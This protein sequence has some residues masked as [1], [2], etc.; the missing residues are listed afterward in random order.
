MDDHEKHISKADENSFDAAGR[1]GSDAWSRLKQAAVKNWDD[2]MLVGESLIEGRTWAMDKAGTNRPEG[3]GY[4]RAFGE[5]LIRYRLDD[6]DKG[7]RSRLFTVME[8]RIEIEGWRIT[9]TSTERM[10]INH[11]STV[12]RKWSAM[13]KVHSG[14]KKPRRESSDKAKLAEKDRAIEHLKEQLASAERRDGSLCDFKHDTAGDIATTLVKSV[15]PSKA[16]AIVKAV[17]ELLKQPKP[18]G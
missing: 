18:A 8:N 13:T 14:E 5:W 15:S 3:G 9:L 10:K 7:D 1:R 11:P 12:L 4:V 2:W 17:Q 6:F 16:K